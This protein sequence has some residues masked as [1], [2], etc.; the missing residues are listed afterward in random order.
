MANTVFQLRRNS[1]SGVRPTTA[2]IQPGELAVNLTDGIVFSTN[3]TTVFELGSNL[4]SLGVGNSTVKYI[5]A[6][7]TTLALANTTALVVNGSNGTSGQVL[8]SNG[9]GLYWSS[10]GVASVNTAAQ[11]TWTN[12]HTFASTVYL[13]N[14]QQLRFKTVNTSAFAGFVQQSD[15]NFVFYTTNTAYGLRAVFSIYAN[16]A[17]AL[18]FSVPVLF[19]TTVTLGSA[20]VSAS[21]STGSSGQYLTSNGTAT[22]WSSPGVASVN[23]NAQWVWSNTHTFQANVSFTGNNISFVSNTGSVFFNGSSDV[24]WRIGRNTGAPTK[25]Y[26]TNNTLDFIA[27]SSPLE[28]IAFGPPSGNTYLEIGYA[29]TFTKNPIY[30]GNSSVNAT[31]NSTSFSG[32][33]SNATNLNSQPGSY[34][35]NATNIT[36]GT[37]PYAQL[38]TNVVNTSANFTITGMYTYSNGITFS[39]TVTASGSNGTAGQVLTSSGATGNVYWSTL[40]GVN[41]AAQYTWTNTHLFQANV[42]V[43]AVFS[44]TNSTSNVAFFAANGNVGIATATPAYSLQVNGSF[45][46]VTKSF[47]INHP[48]KKGMVLRYSSLEGPEH[49]VYFRGRVTGIDKIKLPDY[50]SSLVDA[51]SIT[52]HLTEIGEKQELR[53]KKVTS[54]YVQVSSEVDKSSIDAYYIIHAERKDVPRLEVEVSK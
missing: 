15:D 14:D 24:N 12:T 31:I 5:A 51:E 22:Y 34:Y 32:T 27:A 8:T 23:A 3:G 54:K 25:F 40:T 37:L 49:G 48:K 29:G 11:Y 1:T 13:N 53:V 42:Q 18:S 36:T 38:G 50:W 30:V 47:V 17:S 45:A 52:V 33:A 39:N 2:S 16:S 28:G 44:V 21:G 19:N 4:T 9:T 43:N 7:S 6:N 41:T 26:Y 20:P 10:P 46:A 35:T